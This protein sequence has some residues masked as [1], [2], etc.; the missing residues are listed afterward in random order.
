[1]DVGCS[2]RSGSTLSTWLS[3]ASAWTWAA[4]SSAENPLTVSEY[5]LVGVTPA[6]SAVESWRCVRC[7]E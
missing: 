7:S 4:V 2:F 6:A 3:C 5:R 1:V